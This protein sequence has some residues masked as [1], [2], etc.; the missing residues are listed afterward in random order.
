MTPEELDNVRKEQQ[1]TKKPTGMY[2]QYSRWRSASF[3]EIQQQ[4]SENKEYVIRLRSHG[5][6]QKRMS[7]EDAIRGKTQMIDNYSDVVIRKRMGLPTYH[8][9]HLVD[10]YL[11]GTTHVIRGEEW[12]PSVALHIQLF[13]IFGF[14]AP[15]YA[16]TAQLL[17]LDNGKKRK[18]SKR[19]DPEAN[20]QYLIEQGIPAGGVIDYLYNLV[21]S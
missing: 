19:S 9:A 12:L 13:E 8:F 4:L 16:H 6:T 20:I 15:T 3:E 7:Y 21:D 18:L 17:K 11:M 5:D 2:G 1:I 10:D 14:D